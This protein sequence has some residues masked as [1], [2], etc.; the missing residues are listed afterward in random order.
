LNLVDTSASC[1]KLSGYAV[2]LWHCDRDGLY[3]LYSQGV[4]NQNY[5]RGVQ[6]TDSNGSVTFTTIFPACYAGRMPHIHFEI[7]PSLTKAVV[8]TNKVRTS[9]LAL[10]LDACNAVYATEGY[11]K[12]IQNLSQISFA[13]DNVFSDGT[14]QQL[15]T[16]TGS[17]AA[18]YAASLKVGIAA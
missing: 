6:A 9:Q 14:S 1:A 13:S 2:Y 3:S 7:Y 5:L 16:V 17:V 11:S 18:G 8:Y 10:P 12:S 4:T 15:A